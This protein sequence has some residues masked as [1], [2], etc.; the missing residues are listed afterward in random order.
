[1]A[2]W[3]CW[4][5]NKSPPW[6]AYCALMAGRLVALDKCPGTRPVGIGEIFCRL[7]AKLVLRSAGDQAKAACGNLQL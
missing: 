6:A 4:L 7:W 1:M 3:A 2:E 5:A